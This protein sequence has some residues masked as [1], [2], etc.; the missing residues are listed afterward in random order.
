MPKM[1]T[2][3]D[4]ENKTIKTV[5]KERV[6]ESP[7]DIAYWVGTK[8]YTWKDVDRG[9]DLI[10]SDLVKAGV[11]KGTHVGV[12]GLNSFEWICG[13][14]ALQ[15]LG[16]IIVLI[17][18]NVKP[19]ELVAVTKYSDTE[20]LLAG[21]IVP[22]LKNPNY[23][24]EVLSDP[25]NKIKFVYDITGRTPL[26]TR[27]EEVSLPDYY[28]DADDPSIMIF[29]SGTESFPKAVLLA[30][31]S[32][33]RNAVINQRRFV[34]D[35]EKTCCCMALPMFHIFGLV[36]LICSALVGFKSVII[37]GFIPK[38]VLTAIDHYKCT[39]MCAVP[40]MMLALATYPEFDSFDT[41]S[42][43]AVYIGGAAISTKHYMFLKA[44]FPK[45]RFGIVYGMSELPIVSGTYLYDTLETQIN[46]IG[47]AP[48]GVELKIRDKD[49]GKWCEQGE[50]G[51]I[52]LKS[53][54]MLV[55]YYKL[56]IAKQPIDGD[57]YLH[58]GDLA[59]IDKDG[60]I[61]LAGRIKEMIIRG[62]ENI[63]VNE[64]R[65]I[66]LM[67]PY[68]KDGYVFGIPSEYYGEEVAAAV[69]LLPGTSLTLEELQA[70]LKDK[71]SKYK[72]PTHLAIYDAIP[73]LGNGKADFVSLKA[74]FAKN[75]K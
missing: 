30:H 64:V 69:S 20:Y 3:E 72:I 73:L 12:C 55:S 2:F 9:S 54:N 37:P 59:Y 65:N 45:C 32:I 5:L 53:I 26:L 49:T 51:E 34:F 50:V 33:C 44:K 38:D 74:D 63:A 29:T 31:N 23:V 19:S 41:S 40:T 75:N 10:A 57:G 56:P 15:K 66:M 35:K 52:V 24:Q 67:H 43:T 27:T 71:L 46:T 47:Q 11:K 1:F 68:I 28:I 61:H 58:T 16:A 60:F 48:E 22:A 39:S 70:F 25:D 6:A 7:D 17:N 14:F 8:S 13:F 42:L 62:G 4:V 18:Y 36:P 21:I